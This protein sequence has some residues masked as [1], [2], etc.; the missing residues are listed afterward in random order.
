MASTGTDKQTIL[1][2]AHGHPE[3]SAGGGESA[4]YA[5]FKEL[6][7]RPEIDAYFLARAEAASGHGG[8]PFSVHNG[9]HEIVWHSEMADYFLFSQPN[10]H[11][12]WSAF[13]DFLRNLQPDVVHFHHYLHLGIE[14]LRE[15][16]RVNPDTRLVV[17]LH[18]YWAL[19]HN[20]GQMVKTGSFELCNRSHPDACHRCFPQYAPTD[21][22]L[23][24]LFV[25]SYFELVDLF[26]SPSE[27]LRQRYIGW[28]LPE[29][30]IVMLENGQEP[31]EPPPQRELRRHDR[32]ARFG[33]FGQ[34]NPYKGVHILLDAV[35]KLPLKTRRRFRLDLHGANLENQEE[36]F[37]QGIHEQLEAC[38]G[39]VRFFGPY[40][41]EELHGLMARIDW[42]IVPSTWWEN[43]PL[44]IQ[45]AFKFRRPVICSDI[46][47]M[48]EKVTPGVNGLHF[49]AGNALDL[50]DRIEEAVE[51]P[52]LW[53]QLRSQ[54]EPP[55]TIAETVDRLL[56]TYEGAGSSAGSA[57]GPSGP[58]PSQR[59]G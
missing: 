20:N 1:I 35:E 18:D 39:A 50:A 10:K 56:A 49:R 43:S 31:I 4:A 32:R 54:I 57:E 58:D 13:R 16:K 38:G 6:A 3:A 29:D 53:E 44:V 34:V 36:E 25:K 55:A 48:A 47:G 59:V 40:R 5:A 42:V 51:T 19:C 9:S 41:P 37:A 30:R 17:T 2:V 52:G 23:R 8:T 11:I 27:F 21:F 24:E 45:E 28:G 15:V 22:F 46:G 14:L 26:I 12:V 33:F 7:R